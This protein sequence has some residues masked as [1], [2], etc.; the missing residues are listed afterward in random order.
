MEET[1]FVIVGGGVYGAALAYEL[2]AGGSSVTL[3]E[4]GTL[5][6]RASGGPGK[7]GVRANQ[8]NS[9]ELT[10]AR[11]SLAVWP[12]LADD[13]DGDTGFER[14]GGLLVVE[15]MPEFNDVGVDEA[16]AHLQLQAAHGIK[17]ERV[18]RS[19][20][21]ELEPGLA[22]SEIA[23]VFCPDEGIAD[24][25]STTRAYA[26]AAD[27]RGASIREFTAVDAVG[28]GSRPFVRLSDGSTVQAGRA[29]VL[30]TNYGT[31]ALLKRSG[32]QQ[33]PVWT[34]TPQVLLFKAKGGYQPRHLVNHLHKP[35]SVK[36]LADSITM[37]SGGSQGRWDSVAEEGSAVEEA[38]GWS[39]DVA[40]S[41]FPEL[42]EGEV[43]E[44]DAG[45][46]ETYSPDGLPYIDF[47]D[48]DRK[49]LL[50]AGWSGHGFAIAPA[51][52]HY[53]AQWLV[54][55]DKPDLLSPFTVRR[56]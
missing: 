5:G 20:L 34:Q 21:E 42:G 14:L 7:R 18:D 40:G 53:I 29:V 28:T 11:D 47:I 26:A 31:N 13:L 37:I 19:G 1:D 38:I 51:V 46:P 54:T 35:L 4:A 17:C 12:T 9:R 50:A 16:D 22:E 30:A 3:L 45:R 32:Q 49:I 8:R 10:L 56:T 2:V 15:S 23:A 43:V 36:P 25:Q 52:A 44:A 33:L 6:S 24:Q 41:V 39:R 27:R 48:A 55:G